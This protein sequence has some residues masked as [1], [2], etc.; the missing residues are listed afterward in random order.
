MWTLLSRSCVHQRPDEAQRGAWKNIKVL[1][2][3]Q[4]F[5][6]ML[7]HIMY[8]IKWV[9]RTAFLLK[10]LE[11]S[12]FL[13][14]AS[15]GHPHSLACG[16]FIFL[17]SKVASSLLSDFCFHLCIIYETLS[18]LPHSYRAPWLSWVHP[19]ILR[20]KI[21]NSFTNHIYKVPSVI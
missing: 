3:S 16:L 7:T 1:L 8:W 12:P 20:F 14:P 18:L 13:F 15:R 5:T 21:L 9:G 6:Q 4:N 11:D 10:A 17:P 2:Y 19:D